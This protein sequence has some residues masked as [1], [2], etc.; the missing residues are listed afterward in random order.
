M[1]SPFNLEVCRKLNKKRLKTLENA[2]SYSFR[3][4]ILAHILNIKKICVNYKSI[5]IKNKTF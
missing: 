2:F 3:V 5:K 4:R 1:I